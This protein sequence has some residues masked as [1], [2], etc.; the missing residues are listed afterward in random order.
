M[1]SGGVLW[2][3]VSSDGFFGVWVTF[4]YPVNVGGFFLVWCASG[5]W[6]ERFGFL[7]IFA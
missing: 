1:S 7:V 5:D 3:L 4:L 2:V 6:V